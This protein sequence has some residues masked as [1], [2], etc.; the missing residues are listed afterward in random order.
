[1]NSEFASKCASAVRWLSHSG[2]DRGLHQVFPDAS[3]QLSLLEAAA[4]EDVAGSSVDHQAGKS[5]HARLSVLTESL[6]R[7]E[8]IGN[9]PIVGI[10]GLLNSGKSSL[11]AT[12]LSAA[13]RNRVLRGTAND[14]GTHRFVLWLPSAWW[15]EPSLLDNLQQHL[16]AI[17]GCQPEMLAGDPAEAFRQYNGEVLDRSLVGTGVHGYSPEA[18]AMPSGF[19]PLRVPLLAHDPELDKLGLGL[20]DCPDI[21][22]AFWNAATI[23]TSAGVEVDA[24]ELQQQRRDQLSRVGRLCS[25]FLVV[26]KFGSLGEQRL[27][28]IFVTLR[29]TMPGVPRVLAVNKVKARYSPQVVMAETQSIVHKFGISDVYIAYDFRSHWADR[30]VP[31]SP[32][33]L[34]MEQEDPLPIFF[35]PSEEEPSTSSSNHINESGD[36]SA[37]PSAERYLHHL[38]GLLRPSSLVVDSRRS[39]ATQLS[40]TTAEVF[41]WLEQLRRKRITQVQHAWAALAEACFEFMAERDS[42]GGVESLRLQTSPAIIAQM[43]DSLCRSAPWPMKLGLTIDRSVRQLQSSIVASAGKLSWLRSA[44]AGVSNFIGSFRQGEAGRIVNAE[45][46]A[47]QLRRSDRFGAFECVSRETVLRGCEA[48]LSRFKSE[49]TVRLDAETLDRWS[50]E[51]WKQM[52]MRRKLF[53]GTAPLAP[54]FGPLLAVTLLPLDFGSTAVLVFASTKELLAAAGIAALATPLVGGRQAMEIAE[55]EAAISQLSELFAILCDA[56][57]LPRPSAEQLPV[58]QISGQARKLKDCNLAS[59]TNIDSPTMR[60]WM[61]PM[62]FEERLTVE[63]AALQ[64]AIDAG[65]E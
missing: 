31:P 55:Q 44:G 13:G 61:L 34:I 11:V 56:L 28:D 24:E 30:R 15:S 48:A 59:K 64:N 6:T 2:V 63:L 12:Y 29:E 53:V 16:I 7:I 41:A 47:A 27:E 23:G 39:I 45:K 49:D 20:L 46:F 50:A 38:G 17:F 5:L 32:A 57:G 40:R 42:S 33:T 36:G 19:D 60:M 35:Q 26:T 25:A 14:Q 22:T 3:R 51:T 4:S 62:H 54:I 18:A 58:V 10:A 43:S 9:C 1:M 8:L 52:P 65:R 21:Q 37:P